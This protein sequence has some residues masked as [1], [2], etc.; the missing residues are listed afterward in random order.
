MSQR[1]EVGSAGPK[2][3]ISNS[4]VS[5]LTCVPTV[6]GLGILYEFEVSEVFV[7]KYSSG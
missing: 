7:N 4:D 1:T 5:G 3:R 6:D 2:W